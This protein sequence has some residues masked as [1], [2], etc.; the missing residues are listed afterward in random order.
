MTNFSELV[1]TY[2][3]EDLITIFREKIEEFK[4]PLHPEFSPKQRNY[5]IARMGSEDAVRIISVRES[6][7]DNTRKAELA[8]WCKLYLRVAKPASKNPDRLSDTDI[9][10][11]REFPT[12]ELYDGKLIRSGQ[13]FKGLCPFHGEKSPSFYFYPENGGYSFHCYSCGAHGNNALD[14]LMKLEKLPFKDA[15]RRLA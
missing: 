12:H 6:I 7:R 13:S 4:Q 2:G 11:A 8:Y 10:N 5:L 15:V 1:E 14:Y 3:R 9:D